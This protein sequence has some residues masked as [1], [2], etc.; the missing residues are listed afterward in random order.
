MR[1]S[2]N[3]TSSGASNELTTS[4]TATS[5]DNKKTFSNANSYVVYV[6]I[7]SGLP[8][9]FRLSLVAGKT[10]SIGAIAGLGVTFTGDAAI[11]ALYG[12]IVTLEWTATDTY[13][14]SLGQVPTNVGSTISPAFTMS[15]TGDGVANPEKWV[16]PCLV[17]VNALTTTDTATTDLFG[18]LLY[19][20]DF[21][22]TAKAN[23]FWDYG[24]RPGTQ[25]KNRDLEPIAAHVYD[26]PGTYVI[27]L[28]VVNASG[29]TN[30]VKQT[31]T[32]TDPDV[33]FSGT[34]TVCYSPTGDF[35]E[36]IPGAQQA[37]GQGTDLAAIVSTYAATGKRLMLQAGIAYTTATIPTIT[38]LTNGQI[39]KFGAGTNPKLRPSAGAATA[40]IKFWE[41]Y[42]S[43]D[44]WQIYDIDFDNPSSYTGVSSVIATVQGRAT[45]TI[46]S[47]TGRILCFRCNS[48]NIGG[49]MLN[50]YGNG[51]VS[52][53]LNGFPSNAGL[54]GIWGQNINMCAQL[55]NFIDN[56]DTGE[57]CSRVQGGRNY[58]VAHNKF[59]RPSAAKHCFTARG[60][61]V[62]QSAATWT[63]VTAKNLGDLI[64]PTVANGYVYLV[65]AVTSSSQRST[66]AEE[67]TYPTTIGQ[68]V[69]DGTLT[70]R[71]EYTDALPYYYISNYFCV[72][73]N[74]FDTENVTGL[75]DYA[76][77]IVPQGDSNYEVIEK[78]I[79]RRNYYTK[80]G[81]N[82]TP[83]SQ[84]LLYIQGSE[85]YIQNNIF[86]ISAE[87]PYNVVGVRVVGSNTAG[88]PVPHDVR[89]ENNT[90]YGDYAS[91]TASNYQYGVYFSSAL[92]IGMVAKNN[93]MYA[94]LAKG[95][96]M[97]NDA[98]TTATI[99]NNTTD[100]QV[101][102]P[103]PFISATPIAAADFKLSTASYAIGA[104]AVLDNAF[105]DYFGTTRSRL[106]NPDMGAIDATS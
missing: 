4:R 88:I 58:V 75:V 54:V 19:T 5:S 62:S 64:K 17:V 97:V 1:V 91:P 105:I 20:W 33:V 79:W 76:T 99:S 61:A 45:N 106:V 23:E 71:C 82:G 11:T 26:V 95:Q 80:N 83:H 47:D 81:S 32:V 103:N 89:I 8:R 13:R 41:R 69:M 14:V 30:A 37:T 38:D 15:R 9:D 44:N 73:D 85:G 34:N 63:S 57:H 36:A 10:G 22:D 100:A 18:D 70:L 59:S 101:L 78:F 6:T 46:N 12:Q 74:L 104:G 92:G 3:V 72:Y 51:V 35:S 96:K 43:V 90:F 52:C 29:A 27:T 28:T 55:G 67:P 93:L 21:G 94:P 98:T 7:P 86:N 31:I 39:S 84:V 2:S 49:Y 77:A 24:A 50:G 65:S 40:M 53:T 87:A 66:G 42:S 16:A 56:A 48:T 25:S 102:T 68:T 60:S